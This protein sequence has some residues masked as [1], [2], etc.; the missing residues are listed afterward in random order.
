[1][2]G[3]EWDVSQGCIALLGSRYIMLGRQENVPPFPSSN[4][5]SHIYSRN[6]Q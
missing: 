3:K 2:A 4:A 6:L 5:K 1:M